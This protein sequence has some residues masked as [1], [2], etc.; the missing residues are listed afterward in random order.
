MLYFSN[1]YLLHKNLLVNHM[2]FI[3]EKK[4]SLPKSWYLLPASEPQACRPSPEWRTW[5]RPARAHPTTP[6]HRTRWRDRDCGEQCRWT[7]LVPED[8]I[9][10]VVSW[11]SSDRPLFKSGLTRNWKSCHWLLVLAFTSISLFIFRRTDLSVLKLELKTYLWYDGNIFA[12][13]FKWNILR[14]DSVDVDV[15]FAWHRQSE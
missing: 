7:G 9:D 3:V 14:V 8:T 15:A 10:Y 13:S 5:A 11:M 2:F 6:R 1:L 12:Q 4:I